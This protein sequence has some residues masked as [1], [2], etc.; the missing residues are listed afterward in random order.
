[1]RLRW[2]PVGR[3]L[4]PGIKKRFPSAPAVDSPQATTFQQRKKEDDD[5]DYFKFVDVG[6]D[7]DYK[8]NCLKYKSGKAWLTED[9]SKD[10]TKRWTLHD[11]GKLTFAAHGSETQS[12]TKSG[13]AREVM[14]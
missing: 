6:E 11:S 14:N 12:P 13:T 7:S 5:H 10:S 4:G 1:M 2:L 3:R 8:D 9:C